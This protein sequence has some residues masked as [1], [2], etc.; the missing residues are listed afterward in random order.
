MLNPRAEASEATFKVSVA[1]KDAT[2]L[3]G[4]QFPI[5][6][7]RKTG[8]VTVRMPATSYAIVKLQ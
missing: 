1:F 2:L 3:A 5:S 4:D 8:D 6:R 7:N